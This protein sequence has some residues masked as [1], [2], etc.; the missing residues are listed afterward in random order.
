[1]AVPLE[2]RRDIYFCRLASSAKE[3]TVAHLFGVS[4]SFVNLVYRKF[5]DLLVERFKP[6]YVKLPYNEKIEAHVRQFTAANGFSQGS[7]AWDG[8]D[9]E[10][11]PPELNAQ[12]YYD[13]RVA[14]C[15]FA[16]SG[17]T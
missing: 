2:K 6:R 7:G 15:Y 4:R 17:G 3:R 9:I 10:V 12:D 11:S 14:Q 13:Y 1:M 16:C 8:C 5:C